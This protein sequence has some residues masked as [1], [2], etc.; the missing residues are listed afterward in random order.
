VS[1]VSTWMG[2]P[3]RYKWWR[4]SDSGVWWRPVSGRASVEL[5]AFVAMVMRIHSGTDVVLSGYDGGCRHE[6]RMPLLSRC[7]SSREGGRVADSRRGNLYCLASELVFW[8][9]GRVSLLITQVSK[10]ERVQHLDG[11]P[12]HVT[13]SLEVCNMGDFFSL[14]KAI[15]YSGRNKITH[16]VF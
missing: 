13:I 10:D 16:G 15:C 4:R 14:L 7:Q 9:C 3:T 2:D 5:W 1:V 8:W 12:L 6:R 11:W